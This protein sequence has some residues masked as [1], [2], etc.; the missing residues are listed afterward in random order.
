[1]TAPHPAAGGTPRVRD[2]DTF[3]STD[4]ASSST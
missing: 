3:A 1:M 4:R 2:Y